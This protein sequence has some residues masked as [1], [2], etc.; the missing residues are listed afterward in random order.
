[1]KVIFTFLLLSLL[2]FPA[3]SQSGHK[4]TVRLKNYN[5]GQIYLGNYFGKQ[6]YLIDSA[7]LNHEGTAVFQG[8]D[9]LPG[10][11]YFI[12]LPEKH[13]YFE[14]LVDKQQH[15]GV[16]ADTT[17]HFK[18]I[19]FTNSTDNIL[20]SRY[21]K[22]LRQQQGKIDSAKQ[23]HADSAVIQ[24]LQ[25]S[26]G[27]NIQAYREKYIQQHPKSMLAMIFLAMEDP[28]VPKNKKASADSAFA[29]HY[30]KNHYWDKIDFSDGR[31]VRTPILETRLT[32]YFTQLV[33]P[34]ADSINAEAD[35]LLA[36]AKANKEVFKFMLWWLTSTYEQSPYMGMD[37]VFVHL[38]EKYYI[39]G[40]AYWLT[41]D[42]KQKII[43]RAAQIAPNLIGNIAPPLTLKTS[44]L[45]SVSL[46]DIESKYIVLVFWDPTCGHCQIEVPQ[47]DSAFTHW[48]NEGVKMVG[49][50]A[51][52]TRQQWLDFIKEHHLEDW[53][54]LWAPDQNS[55]YRQLYDVYMTPVVYLLDKN[56][57]ILA[58]KLNVKQLDNF[59]DHLAQEGRPE[60]VST[61]VK[62]KQRQ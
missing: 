21:N 24:H 3:F 7:Q 27:K 49:V 59:L 5:N 45:K 1:M 60:M 47:L 26:I 57:K 17:D 56:K 48:K 38:V 13:R 20:F 36:Q 35:K 52:G 23:V 40:Q 28:Q 61:D 51:G 53:I 33:P 55:T 31:I 46:S 6:T 8:K 25:Q 14:M 9:T 18:D 39:T 29:Y 22:F 10:G 16:N 62:S 42:Q 2:Y 15:F 44:D 41:D 50:L 4:I 19:T 34:V 32:R 58:K 11:I 30:Y 37:A 12:L 43:D 54:N